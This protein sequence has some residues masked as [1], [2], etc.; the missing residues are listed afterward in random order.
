MRARPLEEAWR[1]TRDSVGRRQ[2]PRRTSLPAARARQQ[3][4]SALAQE[5][6]RGA[7]ARD[8]SLADVSE[9]AQVEAVEQVLAPAQQHGPDRKM[10]IVD[11]P[12]LERLADG[13]D[14]AA[15]A[16]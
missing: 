2:V 10:Q 12:R 1:E 8:G 15:Q 13:R 5:D 9:R 3:P 7:L 4:R 6:V 14:A 16:D 11:Q